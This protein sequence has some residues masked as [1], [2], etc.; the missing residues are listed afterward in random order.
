MSRIWGKTIKPLNLHLSN[1]QFTEGSVDE[2][3]RDYAFVRTFISPGHIS[4]SLLS[5][6][7]AGLWGAKLASKG[8]KIPFVVDHGHGD[9][10]MLEA[11]RARHSALTVKEVAEI[12]SL[13]QREIYKLAAMNQIPHFK[14]GSSVRFDPS[15]VLVWLEARML[16]PNTRR[17]AS[18]LRPNRQ[19]ISKTA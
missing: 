6:G 17:K 11:L 3:V 10:D 18:P 12:L 2:K 9:H 13:S 4:S 1:R 15:T 5:I 7:H 19:Q 8:Y 14:V 16:L